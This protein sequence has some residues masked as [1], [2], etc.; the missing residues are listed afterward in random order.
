MG[1]HVDDVTLANAVLLLLQQNSK[2]DKRV[3]QEDV[4]AEGLRVDL[5]WIMLRAL[6]EEGWAL[7]R[8]DKDNW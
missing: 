5:G 8:V 3:W 2:D 1:E 7:V 4:T 6:R